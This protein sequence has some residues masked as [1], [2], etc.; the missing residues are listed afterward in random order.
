[1]KLFKNVRF[2]DIKTLVPFVLAATVVVGIIIF[3]LVNLFN[4]SNF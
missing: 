2:E 3:I 4:S 1:M